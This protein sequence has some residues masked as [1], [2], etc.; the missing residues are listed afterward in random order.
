MNDELQNKTD[1]PQEAAYQHEIQQPDKPFTIDG[2]DAGFSMLDFWQYQ[3]SNLWDL[4]EHIA[5]FIVGMALGKTEP[6][7][8]NGW[9]LY[10]ILYREKKIEVKQVSDWHS[11][12]KDGY[13]QKRPV[14]TINKAY[15]RYKDNTSE[16]KRQSDVYVFCHLRGSNRESSNP[17]ILNHWDFYVVPTW[18]INERCGDNKT[19][20]L[21]VVKKLAN[22]ISF[23]EL[24]SA[25]DAAL[26]SIKPRGKQLCEFL[27][28]I[29]VKL[30]EANGITY[31]PHVCTHE[32]DCPGT[33]P[34]C[35]EELDFLDWE[36][37]AIARVSTVKYDVLSDEERRL[38][39]LIDCGYMIRD[40]ELMPAPPRL[41]GN[42][43]APVDY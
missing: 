41:M 30:A 21:S 40:E 4:Q 37:R 3:F 28:S 17:L 26:M 19:I 33:C 15:S 34:L 16:L 23:G 38:M 13:V 32:G 2:A 22:K 31:E 9:G 39:N 27:R 8:R 18:T 25:V 36:I 42:I 1:G 14:F 12:N 5:E 29:R 35:D 10:D 7:N 43:A 6:S 11:W 20:A 24:R